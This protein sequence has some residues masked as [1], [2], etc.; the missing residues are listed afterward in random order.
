MSDSE[1]EVVFRNY[2]PKGAKLAAHT[3]DATAT[4]SSEVR[5]QLEESVQSKIS[6]ENDALVILPTDEAADLRRILDPRLR[7]LERRTQEAIVE[8]IK[9]KMAAEISGAGVESS[10][11]AAAVA[12]AARPSGGAASID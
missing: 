10:S 11:A 6:D 8:L 7:I 3:V 9:Q 2:K 5:A 1:R 4:V 12:A